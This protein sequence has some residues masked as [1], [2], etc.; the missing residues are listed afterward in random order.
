M[1]TSCANPSCGNSFRF[2]HSGRLYLFDPTPFASLH[3]SDWQP[4][5]H[6][7]EHFWL[8]EDCAKK[9]TLIPDQ[10][11]NI[12]LMLRSQCGD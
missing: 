7:G 3:E 12:K 9:M 6:H 2:L 8:C 1:L 11:G 5:P 10:E 4:I